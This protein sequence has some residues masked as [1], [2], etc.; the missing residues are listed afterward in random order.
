MGFAVQPLMQGMDK[1]ATMSDKKCGGGDDK[2][3]KNLGIGWWTDKGVSLPDGMKTI[4]NAYTK[5]IVDELGADKVNKM[6]RG[7]LKTRATG[8][9]GSL[10][11]IGVGT[12]LYIHSHVSNPDPGQQMSNHRVV[13]QQAQTSME[14]GAN[15]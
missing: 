6:L 10:V 11:G 7:K 15:E 8:L 2:K 13:Q 9:V 1:M 12:G 4:P 5:E 14:D 3:D